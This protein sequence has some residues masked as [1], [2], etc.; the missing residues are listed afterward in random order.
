MTW[1]ALAFALE[2]GFVPRGGVMAFEREPQVFEYAGSYYYPISVESVRLPL[3]FY[4]D[5]NIELI[6]FGWMFA[7]GGIKVPIAWDK[8]T[9]TFN[10]RATYYDFRAGV[11]FGMFELF[12]RHRC[13]HPQWT[14]AYAYLPSVWQ[15]GAYDE[16]A[17]RFSGRT[18]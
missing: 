2:I 18:K 1:L 11:R 10:P 8:E 17:I 7:G 6:L 3:M 13:N 14:Y 12:W 5:L 9:W 15:E 16:I 4:T